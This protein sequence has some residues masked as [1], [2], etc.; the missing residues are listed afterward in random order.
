MNRRI[1]TGIFVAVVCLG[2]GLLTGCGSSSSKTPPPP[3]PPTKANYVFYASGQDTGGGTGE[4]YYAIAGALTIDSNGKVL[5]GEEDYNDAFG[6]TS[7]N[8]PNPDTIAEGGTLVTD[9]TTGLGTLTITSSYTSY[10]RLGRADLCRAVCQLQ[11][12]SDRAV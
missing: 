10:G 7:P 12:R 11:P 6:I 9:P 4:N 3:P 8:E 2:I 5:G 1:Y